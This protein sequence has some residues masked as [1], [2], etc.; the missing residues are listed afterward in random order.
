MSAPLP[1]PRPRVLA[2]GALVFVA[3]ASLFGAI[4]ED[5]VT[6]DA[7]TRHDAAI[8]SWLHQHASPALTAVMRVVTTLNSTVAIACYAT[9]AALLCARRREWRR[10]VLIVVGIYGV[11][12]LNEVLK[13]SF[14]RGRPVFDD[15]LLTLSTYSFPSGHV[16]A[17]TVFYGLGVAW[18]FTRTRRVGGRILAIA[19]ALLAVAVVAFSR[20]YL[21]VHYLSDVGA[22]FAEGIAWLALC[23]SAR[24]AF[25]R[26]PARAS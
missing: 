1:A 24:C 21:G 14:R 4:A 6:L 11:L 8:A 23:L 3:A 5:V 12:V 25:W 10:V 16:A 22:G 13:L 15:P 7:L 20:M 2:I 18:V 9:L 26:H 19:A 17:S